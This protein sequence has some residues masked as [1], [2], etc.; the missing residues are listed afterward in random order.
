V[1][2]LVLNCGSSSVKFKFFETDGFS[3]LARGEVERLGMPGTRLWYEGEK[4]G[5]GEHPISERSSGGDR[6]TFVASHKRL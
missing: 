5:V 6:V 4:R 1:N 3:V 2:I